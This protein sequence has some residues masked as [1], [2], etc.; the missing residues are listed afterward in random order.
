M[1]IN[2]QKATGMHF[3]FFSI[4]LLGAAILLHF[5]QLNPITLWLRN[6]FF[7]ISIL[8]LASDVGFIQ[9]QHKP[10]KLLPFG[11]KIFGISFKSI[12]HE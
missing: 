9:N 10:L 4:S 1:Y 8:L 7:I 6:G 12:K 5:S 3:A 11:Q 2:A